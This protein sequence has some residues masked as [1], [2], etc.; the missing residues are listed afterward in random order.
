MIF[1]KHT[2]KPNGVNTQEV[3]FRE[4]MSQSKRTVFPSASFYF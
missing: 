1:E 4:K 3:Y 2:E